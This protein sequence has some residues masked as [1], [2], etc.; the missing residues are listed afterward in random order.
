MRTTGYI[1]KF[2]VYLLYFQMIYIVTMGGSSIGSGGGG[3]VT[4]GLDVI[5]G[6][7]MKY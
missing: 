6:K 4:N 7:Q 3:G 5:S 2:S 1:L